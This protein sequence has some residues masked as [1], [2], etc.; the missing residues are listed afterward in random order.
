MRLGLIYAL[1]APLILATSA[2]G[3]ML[4]L[5]TFRY[6]LLYTAYIPIDTYGSVYFTAMLDLAWGLLVSEICALGLFILKI[7]SSGLGHDFGQVALICVTL[8]CSIRYITFLTNLYRP[9]VESGESE[10]DGTSVREKFRQRRSLPDLLSST[11]RRDVSMWLPGDSFGVSQAVTRSILEN[12]RE[13]TGGNDEISI[14]LKG[15]TV[16]RG[17]Q[18]VLEPDADE[19]SREL[20]LD[21]T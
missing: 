10:Q 4:V 13:V 7:E 19:V 17:G 15:C 12:A 9:R 16:T 21:L 14:I 11:P 20:D 2:L 3:F 8:F 1:L 6:I 5:L 18:V